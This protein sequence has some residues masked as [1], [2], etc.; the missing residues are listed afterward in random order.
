MFCG[1]KREKWRLENV[2]CIWDR[3]LRRRREAADGRSSDMNGDLEYA[4]LKGAYLG[5]L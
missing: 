3:A 1:V 2:V 5:R 4:T